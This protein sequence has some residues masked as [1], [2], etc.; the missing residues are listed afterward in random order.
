MQAYQ[1]AL[2]KFS[3]AFVR[4]FALALHLPEDYFDKKVTYPMATIRTLHYP[5]MKGREDEETGLGAHTD[6]ERT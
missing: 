4:T 1:A 6:I 2:L 3:R 5:P